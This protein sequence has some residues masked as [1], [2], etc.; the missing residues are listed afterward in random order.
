MGSGGKIGLKIYHM[1]RDIKQTD[2]QTDTRTSRLLDRIGPV[3]RFDENRMGRG[4]DT[5]RIWT[6]IASIRKTEK[7]ADT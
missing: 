5:Y 4:Q 7:W 6:D 3:S 1:K 2:R